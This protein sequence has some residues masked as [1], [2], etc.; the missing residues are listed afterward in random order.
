MHGGISRDVGSFDQ[1]AA[2]QKPTDVPDYGLV[3]DLLWN[4]PDDD[5]NDW[6]ENERGCGQIFG[7]K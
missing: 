3:A 5:I 2:I 4:D 1:I 6:E 7:K